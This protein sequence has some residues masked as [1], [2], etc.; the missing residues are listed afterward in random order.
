VSLASWVRARLGASICILFGIV[1][2]VVRAAWGVGHTGTGGQEVVRALGLLFAEAPASCRL[3]APAVRGAFSL[4]E[5]RV[6]LELSGRG[7]F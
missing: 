5:L 3:C 7:A 2:R 4:R 6:P 1:R